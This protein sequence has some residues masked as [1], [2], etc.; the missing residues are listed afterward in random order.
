MIDLKEY[1]LIQIYLFYIKEL[2]NCNISLDLFLG[3]FY[4]FCHQ[5]Y[6]VL[7]ILITCFTRNIN[8]LCFM[9]LILFINIYSII[10]CKTCPIYLMEQKYINTSF[11][12]SS[13]KMC[14]VTLPSVKK[15]I[16]GKKHFTKYLNYRVDEFT[17]QIIF[18]AYVLILLKIMV[19][20]IL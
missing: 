10:K 15:N 11:F 13:M 7:F 5:I 14:G 19:L 8:H 20:I 6:F 16:K 1:D 9:A 12:V 3:V 2:L 17:L 18:S 4:L